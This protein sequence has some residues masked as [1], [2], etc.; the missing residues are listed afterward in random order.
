LFRDGLSYDVSR[1]H[2]S[3]NLFDKALLYQ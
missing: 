1:F 3:D 2:S